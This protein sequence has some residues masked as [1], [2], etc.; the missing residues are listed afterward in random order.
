MT[1]EERQRE[2]ITLLSRESGV[3]AGDLALR[4]KVSRM[5]IH[6]DLRSLF[7]QGMLLRIR[8]GA[9]TK[10]L[11][12]AVREGDCSACQRRLIPH[13]CSEIHRLDGTINVTCCA[14]CGLRQ[15]R[16]NS[17]SGQILV[18]DQISGQMVRAQDAFFLMN[19]LASPCCK[20]SLLSFAS[21]TE[22]A[23]FQAGFG[24][25]IARMDE[26]LEFLRVAEGLN[27]I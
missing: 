1:R 15:Y 17:G 20:P 7:K 13:Q 22:V 14:A 3:S 2:I 11:V 24:G 18:G 12:G 9:V 21:E 10:G 4:F 19:S 27:E 6:R 23:L 26:A 25:S 5:T 16:D 8:G